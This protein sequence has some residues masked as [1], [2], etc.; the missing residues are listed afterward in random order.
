MA[1]RGNQL[2]LG[3]YVATFLYSLV[4]LR[5]IRVIGTDQGDYFV[6]HLAVLAVLSIGVL[7]YFIHHIS[8]S[9]QVWTLAEQ[10]RTDLIEVVNRLYPEGSGRDA[11]DVESGHAEPDVP[12][13]L[14]TDGVHLTSHETGY[15]QSVDLDGLLS[16]AHAHDLLV[17]LKVRPGKH[18][19]EGAAL[20]V[21]WPLG[22]LNDNLR[23]SARQAVRIGRA[24]TP[25][26]DVEFAALLLENGRSGT[27]P[28]HQ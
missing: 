1:D 24:R 11:R 15:V 27:F 9:V 22:D 2:V 10:V 26:E 16:L 21:L 28:Q 7:V 8:D 23:G 14:D 13:Q 6:P 17:S 12:E 20:A 5:S 4:V 19:A 3:V 18:V 25:M